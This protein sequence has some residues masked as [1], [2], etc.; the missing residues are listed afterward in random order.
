MTKSTTIVFILIFAIL[1]KLEKKSWH[2]CSIVIMISLGLFLFTYKSTQFNIF[3]FVLLLFASMSSGLRW[4]CTQLLLQNAKMGMRNPID[5]IFHMQPFM[6]ISLLP[7]AIWIEGAS[8]FGKFED[9]TKDPSTWHFIL[10]RLLLGAS[11][12]FF[13]E[14]TEVLVVSFTSSLTLSI[15]GIFKVRQAIVCF[16]L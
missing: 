8:L 5:M 3:G 13:M 2:L 7:F 12:G 6:F 1:F 16:L 9:F 4:T 14:I 11:I 15:A 10:S